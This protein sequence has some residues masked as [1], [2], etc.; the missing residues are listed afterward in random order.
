M[1]DATTFGFV[2]VTASKSA[3]NQVF[4][5]WADFLDL[6]DVSLTPI[7]LPLDTS[8][9]QYREVLSRM[10]A[11]PSFR[12]A[13]VTSHKVRILDAARDMFVALDEAASVLGEVSC[14]AHR[15]D[16][17]HGSAKDPYTS[18][19]SLAAFVPRAHFDVTGGEV[20]C[21]GAGGS[22]MAIAMHLLTQVD[23]EERPSRITIVNRSRPRLD[24]CARMLRELGVADRVRLVANSDPET[25]D[26][27]MGEMPPGSLIINATGMGKDS[28]GS[29]VTDAGVF[30]H[31]GLVWELNYR[32]DLDFLQQARRQS[33]RLGHIEDGWRYFIHGWSSV[34]AEVF[35]LELNDRLL[36]QLDSAAAPLR[37]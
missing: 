17:L 20:L 33:G 31:S 19:R 16:G 30:P 1:R 22:G 35:D 14:I 26:A 15:A 34:V 24:E 28:P 11:D 8:P 5:A 21:F 18:G 6:G 9:A 25:N 29:P 2:G 4:P 7:D 27:L 37:G 12:G 23:P 3:I 32:G 13:L 10:D 36:T